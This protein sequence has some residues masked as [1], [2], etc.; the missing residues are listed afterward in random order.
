MWTCSCW[1]TS[2]SGSASHWHATAALPREVPKVMP[3][4]MPKV[5]K[6]KA[7][8]EGGSRSLARPRQRCRPS[9]RSQTSKID[10]R[11]AWP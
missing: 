10:V 8:A 2:C 11:L 4:V 1:A 9:P 6:A 7:E 5:P 3:K